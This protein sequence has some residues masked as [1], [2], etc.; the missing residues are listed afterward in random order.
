MLC[1]HALAQTRD[2]GMQVG[3]NVP[4]SRK[5]GIGSDILF[6]IGYGQFYKNGLGFRTG[7]QY[8]ASVADINDAFGVPIA[9]AYKTRSRSSGER[10]EAGA[11][12]A[13]NAMVYRGSYGDG[14][15]ATRGF[16]GGFLLNLFSDTEFF[17]GITP[18][19]VAGSSGS[20]FKASWGNTW[21]YWEET[22]VEKKYAFSLTLDAG[23]SLNYS[24]WR[25]DLKLTPAIHYHLTD[26]FIFH[27]TVGETGVGVKTDSTTPLR[28]FFTL[29]GGIAFRF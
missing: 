7:I 10:F 15:D 25:F 20:P 14:R 17:A 9:F 21:Q 1:F 5:A 27:S 6:G 24:I 12:G 13:R 4:M 29:N 11:S 23:L 26:N 3:V 16:L 22:Y 2:I 19:Y 28:W 18:G 8:S